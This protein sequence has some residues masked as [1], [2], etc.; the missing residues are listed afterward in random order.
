MESQRDLL[1]KLCAPGQSNL[2]PEAPQPESASLFLI[3]IYG[4]DLSFIHLKR[5]SS[6]AQRVRL[7]QG[8]QGKLR[9]ILETR[10]N[11]SM[12]TVA[13]HWNRLT[14]AAVESLCLEIFKKHVDEA[15][16]DMV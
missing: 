2:F 16:E 7:W 3:N 15:L 13:K 10:E 1:E 8:D 4:R 5:S 12:E 11:L 14:K 6:R 9:K